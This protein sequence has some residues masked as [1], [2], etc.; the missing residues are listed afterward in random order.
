MRICRTDD[1]NTLRYGRGGG[2]GGDSDDLFPNVFSARSIARGRVVGTSQNNNNTMISHLV[3][4]RRTIPAS[5]EHAVCS[6]TRGHENVTRSYAPRKGDISNDLFY[7]RP[8]ITPAVPFR[9]FVKTALCLV[10]TTH[11]KYGTYRH[12]DAANRS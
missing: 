8:L 10:R 2:G 11:L 6:R 5:I 1:L 12:G 9:S 7:R 4:T 3:V